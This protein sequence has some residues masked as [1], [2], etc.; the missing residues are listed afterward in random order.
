MTSSRAFTGGAGKAFAWPPP[1]AVSGFSKSP[2]T[3]VPKGSKHGF[4]RTAGFG[5]VGGIARGSATR[6]REAREKPHMSSNET[7]TQ[8]G[9]RV[10]LPWLVGLALSTV[11][12][13]VLVFLGWELVVD[14]WFRSADWPT[15]H[16]LFMTRGITT[17]VLLAAWAA[18]SVWR[19]RIKTEQQRERMQTAVARTEHLASLGRM[20]AGFAHQVHSPLAAALLRLERLRVAVKDLPPAQCGPG[21]KAVPAHECVE[22]VERAIRSVQESLRALLEYVKEPDVAGPSQCSADEVVRSAAGLMG[23]VL[24]RGNVKLN[25]E[26]SVNGAGRV[27]MARHRL[28]SVMAQLLENSVEAQPQGGEVL[29]LLDTLGPDRLRLRILDRGE[30]FTPAALE[31]AG[32][33]FFTTRPL[34][35]GTGLGLALVRKFVEAAGGHVDVRNRDGGGA[36]VELLLPVTPTVEATG[37]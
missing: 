9:A 12:L 7:V 26:S 6:E 28:E 14:D 16:W 2:T 30:G 5:V 15:V 36:E 17:S 1:S 8:D 20:A 22:A 33:P 31:H 21:P 10:S 3:R 11:T 32:E 23:P 24:E 4:Y 25:V 35:Q 19:Y 27:P 29:V 13:A 18:W 34:G 37:P